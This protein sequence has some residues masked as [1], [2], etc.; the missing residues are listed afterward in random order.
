LTKALTEQQEA[1]S[2]NIDTINDLIDAGYAS[3]LQIDKETGAV[4]LDKDAYLVLAQAKIKEQTDSLA[5]DREKYIAAIVEEKNAALQRAGASAKVAVGYIDEAQALLMLNETEQGQ[6]AAY[7]AQYAALEELKSELGQVTATAVSSSGTRKTAAEKA[8]EAEEKA[9]KEA[10]K[11]EEAAIKAQVDAYK[12]AREE[13]DHLR[14]MDLLGEDDY[15]RRL[16]EIRDEHLTGDA[17]S[18][19]SEYRKINEEIHKAQEDALTAQEKTYKEYLKTLQGDFEESVKEMQSLY[20]DLM[21]QQA[22]MEEK[23][24][25]FAADG[26]VEKIDTKQKDKDGKKIEKAVLSDLNKK[27]KELDTYNRVLTELSGRNVPTSLMNEVLGLSVEGAIEYGTL[28]LSQSEGQWKTYVGLYEQLQQR[29]EEISD[30]YFESDIEQAQA[31][32]EKLAKEFDER[33][34]SELAI[35]EEAGFD[36]GGL[37]VD[38]ISE[39]MRAKYDELLRECEVMANELTAKWRE[40]WDEHSPSRVALELGENYIKGLEQGIEVEAAK[41]ERVMARAIP[42]ELTVPTQAQSAA[43]A[44]QDQTA[45]LV[46]AFGTLAAGLRP[47]GEAIPVQISVKLESGVEVARAF[48]SNIRDVDLQSPQFIPA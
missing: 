47:G 36:S 29:A 32:L 41:L 24:K 30:K 46:N 15:Y 43:M 40:A 31:D 39:G 42:N 6:L 3:A 19:V 22:Q 27:L 21:K 28:L 20:D 25:A 38:G 45:T 1:G 2:L 26:L 18:V 17:D 4:I 12:N 13:I 10:A 33:A 11:A 48:I 16:T 9:A 44:A 35:L 23:L 5:I 37:F 14:K 7:D 8:A 34:R